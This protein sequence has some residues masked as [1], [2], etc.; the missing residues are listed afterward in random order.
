MK[1]AAGSRG[2]RKSKTKQTAST[3]RSSKTSSTRRR[4]GGALS[5]RLDS[6]PIM[7]VSPEYFTSLSRPGAN[8]T[9]RP[10]STI[11]ST[12]EPRWTPFGWVLLTSNPKPIEPNLIYVARNP[13][14]TPLC[15]RLARMW[16][17][18][19][20]SVGRFISA[21]GQ[22]VGWHGDD[23]EQRKSWRCNPLMN[24]DYRL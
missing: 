15:G 23:T 22:A 5:S 14:P 4:T 13:A 9:D 8:T 12:S 19:S 2:S 10:S 20:R 16:T 6:S 18:V 24:D 7:P 11:G 3:R 1:T 21:C 17:T